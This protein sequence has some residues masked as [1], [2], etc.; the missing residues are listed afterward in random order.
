MN[1]Q[2]LYS[3]LFNGITDTIES[4]KQLQIE[5]EEDYLQMGDEEENKIVKL[6]VVKGEK[7][8]PEDDVT[9]EE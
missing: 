5:V 4:L 8:A 7:L 2:K 3:K 6:N 1:Y 9:G